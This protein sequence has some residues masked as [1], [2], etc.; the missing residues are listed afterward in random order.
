M[1]LKL[2]PYDLRIIYKPDSEMF[3]VDTISRLPSRYQ[4]NSIPLNLHIH[5]IA[6]SDLQDLYYG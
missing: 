1:I 2:Q 6:F 5:H 3:L 4:T